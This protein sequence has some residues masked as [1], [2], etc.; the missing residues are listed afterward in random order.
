MEDRFRSN[1]HRHSGPDTV[2]RCCP[3]E[4]LAA[5]HFCFARESD[6]H[7]TCRD[8]EGIKDF[9]LALDLVGATGG[10]VTNDRLAKTQEQ[11]LKVKHLVVSHDEG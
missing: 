11:I 10:A 5:F 1:F 2:S 4:H 3:L 9:G 7:I 6:H 8:A